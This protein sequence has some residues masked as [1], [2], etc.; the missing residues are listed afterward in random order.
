MF[1]SKERRAPRAFSRPVA[2]SP[3]DGAPTEWS[4]CNWSEQ[5]ISN[6]ISEVD[7]SEDDVRH[8]S[9]SSSP[10]H[11]F[12][13]HELAPGQRLVPWS[14]FIYVARVVGSEPCTLP[15]MVYCTYS[16]TC[17]L[18]WICAVQIDPA[19]HHHNG[20]LG[21]RLSIWSVCRRSIRLSYLNLVWGVTLAVVKYYKDRGQEQGSFVELK[22]RACSYCG[23]R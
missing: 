3:E 6:P 18:G 23:G 13:L 17:F 1:V 11:R 19:Q 12:P 14:V 15:C 21:C 9:D 7:V 5:R 20:R 16:R 2:G 22:A 8:S 10:D 4:I